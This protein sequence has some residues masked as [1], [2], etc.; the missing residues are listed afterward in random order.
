MAN[1]TKSPLAP[2]HFPNLLPVAG[3]EIGV[4]ESGMKYKGRPDLLFAVLAKGT[5]VAGVF[6]KSKC[7]SAPVDW[8]KDALSTG[9]GTAPRAVGG[10]REPAADARAGERFQTIGHDHH[11]EQKNA[12]AAEYRQEVLHIFSLCAPG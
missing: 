8:S 4:A 3:V 5:A 12:D 6:T 11:A 10:V 1:L 2:A 9:G 7:P